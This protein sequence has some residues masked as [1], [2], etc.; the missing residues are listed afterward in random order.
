MHFVSGCFI[1]YGLNEPV[2]IMLVLLLHPC[3]VMLQKYA[4]L[5]YLLHNAI[6]PN[7]LLV[8]HNFLN[9]TLSFNVMHFHLVFFLRKW[10]IPY[11]LTSHEILFL[12]FNKKK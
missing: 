4:C 8:E 10:D 11:N 3:S 12:T 7:T 5:P 6:A 9:L 1:G 2:I